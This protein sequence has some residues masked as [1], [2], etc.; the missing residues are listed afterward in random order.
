MSGAMTEEAG[1]AGTVRG[2]AAGQADA[3][4]RATAAAVAAML[5]AVGG[6][7]QL[8]TLNADVLG[9][10]SD[11]PDAP[12]T[13]T[14]TITRQTRTLAFVDVLVRTAQRPVLSVAGVLRLQPQ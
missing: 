7:A 14:A 5:E 4:A 11:A 9:A 1:L 13:A 6:A 2:E 8:V 10:A 3:V 12:L